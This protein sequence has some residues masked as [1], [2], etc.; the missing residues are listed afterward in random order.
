MRKSLVVLF[1]VLL[2]SQLSQAQLLKNFY[3]PKMNP[4]KPFL[5]SSIQGI[6]EEIGERR[7]HTL[8]NAYAAFLDDPQ[9]LLA[10]RVCSSYPLPIV[11]TSNEYGIFWTVDLIKKRFSYETN[12]AGSSR[13]IPLERVFLLRNDKNCTFY[14]QKNFVTEYWLIPK[15]SDLPNFVEIEKL[16]EYDRD[17]LIADS[18]FQTSE[19]L[20]NTLT[21]EKYVPVTSSSYESFKFNILKLA[22]K[23]KFSYFLIEYPNAGKSKRKVFL[24]SSRLKQF[25]VKNNIREERIIVKQCDEQYCNLG[26]EDKYPVYPNIAHIYRK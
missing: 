25:L 9:F 1:V 20:T 7:F 19:D 13:G 24:E 4:N 8:E 15:D 16:D 12:I 10:L 17:D 22:R 2:F 23:N 21:P 26:F 18:H 5:L 14:N 3:D 6:G 11:S